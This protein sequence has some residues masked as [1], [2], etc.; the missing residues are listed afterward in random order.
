LPTGFTAVRRVGDLFFHNFVTVFDYFTTKNFR[1][2]PPEL[3][4][5][6]LRSMLNIHSQGCWNWTLGSAILFK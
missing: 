6:W 5:S 3:P 4:V 2:F 1:G